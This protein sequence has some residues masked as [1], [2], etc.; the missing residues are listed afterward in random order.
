MAKGNKLQT[1]YINWVLTLNA[2]QAQKEIHNVTESTRE[3]EK[4][5]KEFR[6]QMG[7]LDRSSSDYKKRQEELN[8]KIT[9]NNKIITENR[10]KQ[11][12]LTRQL[13]KSQMTANQLAKEMRNL[14]RELRNTSKATDPKRY[15]ELEQELER[16]AKAYRN[17]VSSSKSFGE[18]LKDISK[19]I[20]AV[21]GALWNVGQSIL[22]T[23][24][25]A[26]KNAFNVI[27]DFEAQ[28]SKLA[29]IM[30]STKEGIDDMTQI[31]G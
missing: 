26:F 14:Q 10:E 23:F 25:N 12:L 31:L 20:E 15:K 7:E 27:A 13:D 16:T 21:K 9:A 29:A 24:V 2:S 8:Q 5:N 28:Q 22:S 30:Q 19:P 17:A 6:K 11:K 18:K 4:Q 3:L 1:D